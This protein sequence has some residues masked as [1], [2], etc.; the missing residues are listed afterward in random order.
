MSE[1]AIDLKALPDPGRFSE[2]ESSFAFSETD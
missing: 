1:P 2:K